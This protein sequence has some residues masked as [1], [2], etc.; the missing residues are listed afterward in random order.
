MRGLA[1]KVII[2]TGGSGGIGTAT[3]LRMASEGA[4]V[5]VGDVDEAGAREVAEHVTSGGGSAVGIHVDI[6]DDGSVRNLV[7]RTVSHFGGIDG[8]HA[9]AA[10][11]STATL[12]ADT[13]IVSMEM[14]AFDHILSVNL[15]GHVLCT[16]HVIPALLERGGGALVYT[17][18]D[19][20][21]VG[22]PERPAYAISKSGVCALARHV[23]SKWGKERIRAN[24]VSPGV[25]VTP[26]IAS[27]TAEAGLARYL[28]RTRSW[29][30]GEPDD[31]AAT[32]AHLMSD[33]GEWINGQV[34]SVNG[35]M[36]LR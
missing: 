6:S 33:D 9:N 13:D 30:M 32:V 34:I 26:T 23:A 36:L 24:A 12:A 21:F 28:A 16:R 14:A 27:A 5:V 19:A 35:G 15:R 18:S 20:A 25:V 1:G 31:I 4:S 29:R 3:C 7:E 2:V 11:L 8:L 17:S 10:D 22:E